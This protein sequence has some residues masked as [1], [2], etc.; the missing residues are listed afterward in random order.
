MPCLLADSSFVRVVDQTKGTTGILGILGGTK[1]IRGG[2][3]GACGTV[4]QA[5]QAY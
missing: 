3:L 4:L 1:S 2:L 5:P